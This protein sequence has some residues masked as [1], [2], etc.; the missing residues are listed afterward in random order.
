MTGRALF[1][2]D[3]HPAAGAPHVP[4]DELFLQL[5]ASFIKKFNQ[6]AA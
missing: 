4:I 1:C 6:E 5:K 2:F 3:R